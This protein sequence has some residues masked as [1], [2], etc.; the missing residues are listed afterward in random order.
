MAETAPSVASAPAGDF[1][2]TDFRA[3]LTAGDDEALQGHLER[4]QRALIASVDRQ[5]LALEERLDDRE[6]DLMRAEERKK[7]LG[8]LLFNAQTELRRLNDSIASARRRADAAESERKVA[9]L[10]QQKL[11]RLLEEARA[12]ASRLRHENAALREET[13]RA[14]ETTTQL[15]EL[16][17]A[18]NSDIKIRRGLEGRMENEL[19]IAREEHETTKQ[20]LEDAGKTIRKLE[21][22]VEALKR[23]L[24][25][26]TTEASSAQLT[27]EKL[28]RELQHAA[29]AAK[30]LVRQWEDGLNAMSRRD[31]TLQTVVEES[32]RL[33]GEAELSKRVAYRSE[34]E[35]ERL[36]EERDRAVAEV[37]AMQ[38][39]LDRA[40]VEVS[41][42]ERRNAELLRR[43][44][45]A[46]G[47]A[48]MYQADVE[49]VRTQITLLEDESLRRGIAAAQMKAEREEAVARLQAALESGD[50]TRAQAERD[51][52][53]IDRSIETMSLEQESRVQELRNLN[54]VLRVK[55]RETERTADNVRKEK[56]ALDV[57][58]RHLSGHYEQLYKDSRY[59]MDTLERKQHAISTLTHQ[60]ASV[61]Y[62][63]K[64]KPLEITVRRMAK[65]L[66]DMRAEYEQMKVRWVENQSENVK[67]GRVN[68]KLSES[69][70]ELKTRLHITE[71]IGDRT[72]QEV[73]SLKK[74]VF[75]QQE[76]KSRL[77]AEL[78]RLQPLVQE[79][80]LRNR[81][82]EDR[83][84]DYRRKFAAADTDTRATVHALK[85]EIRQLQLEREELR[86]T[87]VVDLK[88][89]MATERK[90]AITRDVLGKKREEERDAS[91]R[92]HELLVKLSRAERKYAEVASSL[93]TW[94]EQTVAQLEGG[95]AA[96]RAKREKGDGKDEE[97]D[98]E[99][100]R[101]KLNRALSELAQARNE[102]GSLRSHLTRLRLVAL[103]LRAIWRKRGAG[104]C[105]SRRT[106]GGVAPR[107]RRSPHGVC[108]PR[109]WPPASRRSSRNASRMC[110][111]ITPLR[112]TLSPRRCFSLHSHR[113]RR[114]SRV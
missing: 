12:E 87:Q 48:H 68:T 67:L 45:L 23:A 36:R 62:D 92:S 18:Y 20:R 25:R 109:H 28:D 16:N 74:E 22:E 17:T 98:S 14:A 41:V 93:Q 3:P 43:S 39:A 50:S 96:R 76:D 100:L 15:R 64:T 19:A 37:D 42:L 7:D 69:E 58:V 97:S 21:H 55:M 89:Q 80:E 101:L 24:A 91:R 113:R 6:F 78:R 108:V 30:G 56:D 99:L 53:E 70:S 38:G 57:Q 90:L 88:T 114:P 13:V 85:A 59:L 110:R 82:L 66:D 112:P 65:E 31:E 61:N 102:N 111:S 29:G 33:Q 95:I 52:R 94:T 79:L 63:A 5:L 4:V 1:T 104:G 40:R 47:L 46:E 77:H 54:C 9:S 35:A 106:L 103:K 34:N 11:A 75:E 60:L 27:A 51:I 26:K 49:G 86:R 81:L 10:E 107:S 71:T 72:R 8:S 83:C 32:A 73:D 84:E 105:L 44:Q 2:V